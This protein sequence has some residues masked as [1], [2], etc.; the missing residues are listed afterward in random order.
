MVFAKQVF[1]D[2]EETS[3]N[4][5]SVCGYEGITFYIY[6]RQYHVKVRSSDCRLAVV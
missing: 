3:G 2:V 6:S 4:P 1:E 5:N